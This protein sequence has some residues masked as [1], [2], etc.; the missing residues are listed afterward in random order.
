VPRVVGHGDDSDAWVVFHA[1]LPLCGAVLRITCATKTARSRVPKPV[2]RAPPSFARLLAR[3]TGSA[4]N[5]FMTHL[6]M[7]EVDEQG[8]PVEWGEHVTDEEY[9]AAPSI[10]G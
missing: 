7:Q 10:D 9:G 4:S 1:L 2:L 3:S 8:S 5:R 6:A